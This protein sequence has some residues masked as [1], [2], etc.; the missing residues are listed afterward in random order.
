MGLGSGS[1]I[2]SGDIG[3]QKLKNSFKSV[4]EGDDWDD[5]DSH[6]F[7]FSAG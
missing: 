2:G 7:S 5:S 4:D 3:D 1:G 6:S